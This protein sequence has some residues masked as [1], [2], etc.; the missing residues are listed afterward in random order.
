M[1]SSGFGGVHNQRDSFRE[2]VESL[3]DAWDERREVRPLAAAQDLDS[4]RRLL[5]VIH[6]WA[7]KAVGDIRQIY[8]PELQLSLDDGPVGEPPGFGVVFGGA[9]TLTFTV[10][11][12]RRGSAEAWTIATHLSAVGP[13]FL[14]AAAP[15]RRNGQWSRARL[16]EVFL[17]A[18]GMF[19]RSRSADGA[20]QRLRLP[21]IA[22]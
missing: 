18:L 12:K 9:L 6:R 21:R 7:A 22:G 2:R 16:E 4:Q 14:V 13:G 10:T 20:E 1:A 11:E 15:Q 3:R 8:G 19:E 17:S 5:A